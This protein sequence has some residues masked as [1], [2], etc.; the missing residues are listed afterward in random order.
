MPPPSG[1]RE[2]L[3]A[4]APADVGAALALARARGVDRLDAQLLLARHLQQSRTWLLAHAEAP[5]PADT[6]RRFVVDLAHR[7]DGVPLA[8]LL[9]ER[10]FHGLSLEVTPAVLVPRPDTETLVD[11]AM[12]ILSSEGPLGQLAHPDVIDLGTGSGAIAIAVQHACP[13]ARV[14][15][16]DASPD[17]LAVACRN[18][19][20][21]APAVACRHGLWLDGVTDA[22]L[23]LI[24]SNPPYVALGDPH[25]PGLRHEPREALAS[26]PDGLDDLRLI[27]ADAPRCLRPGGW[28][29]LEHGADQGASVRSLLA[30]AGFVQV[31]TR[32]DLAGLPRCTG[33]RRPDA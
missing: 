22:S 15:A 9:G 13:R 12:G 10:E 5:M 1:E 7:A 24:L 18:A 16:V 2:P 14:T 33:G 23:D 4:A 25:W 29:L 27:G 11:W 26:G 17:A 19:A 30:D 6:A 3:Q 21:L 20:R 8:Y 32:H 28:I 31:E